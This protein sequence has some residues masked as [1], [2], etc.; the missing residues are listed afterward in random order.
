MTENRT[1][2]YRESRSCLIGVLLSLFRTS[3]DQNLET[4]GPTELSKLADHERTRCRN[5]LSVPHRTLFGGE[6]GRPE[7]ARIDPRKLSEPE[8]G[9]WEISGH[10]SF[11]SSSSSL[12]SESSSIRSE[13]HLKF[14]IFFN[15][16][17]VLIFSI[18][19]HFDSFGAFLFL[20]SL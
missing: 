11:P 10:G 15:K 13:F 7:T 3:S 12:L 16:P 1:G 18:F 5:C 8:G 9:R 19:T 2:T 14:P 6:R 20:D 17:K 4:E